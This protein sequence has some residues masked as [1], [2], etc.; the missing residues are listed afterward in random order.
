MNGHPSGGPQPVPELV[1]PVPPGVVSDDDRNRFGRLLDT[2]A[3]Q[4]LLSPLDYQN[5]L[6][7]VASAGSVAELQRIVTEIPAFGGP[8]PVADPPVAGPVDIDA[9]L[10]AGRT[11]AI[12]RERGNRWLALVLMV[13]VLLVALIG[14]GLVAAH[15][16]HTHSP[17]GVPASVARLSSLRL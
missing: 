6:A 17:V 8:D 1:G 5:R 4:G 13:A 11:Q 7:Q 12:G 10:W 9:L 3:E 2:A 15:L 14:L 16:A